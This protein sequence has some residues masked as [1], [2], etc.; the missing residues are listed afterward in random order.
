MANSRISFMLTGPPA[1]FM[2]SSIIN[3]IGILS[4]S[5]LFKYINGKWGKANNC[6]PETLR[7]EYNA[8]SEGI[9]S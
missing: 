8:Y 9:P 2:N 4:I 1:S 6:S 3:G 7:H 5:P